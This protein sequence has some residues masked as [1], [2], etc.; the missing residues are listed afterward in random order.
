MR[1]ATAAA[2]PRREI[3][4]DVRAG[5]RTVPGDANPTDTNRATNGQLVKNTRH[6]SSAKIIAAEAAILAKISAQK[7]ASRQLLLY[8]N[9]HQTPGMRR[10]IGHQGKRPSAGLRK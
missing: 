9:A 10:I 6:P 7:S 2:P 1:I 8:R 5:I 3:P 4:F